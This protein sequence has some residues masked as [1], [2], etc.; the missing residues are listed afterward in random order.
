MPSDS[1]KKASKASARPPLSRERIIA[2]A[3][4]I[5]D[6]RGVG[7]V[8]MREVAS[9]LGVEAMSLYNHV[10]NK[11]D[12]LDGMVDS[13]AAQIDLPH[14]LEDWR[15]V[16]R[17]RAVS[18]HG[19]FTRHPWAPLLIDS[20]GSSGPSALH[21]YD[22]ILGTLLG[23]GFRLEDAARAFSLLDSYIYGFGIE[24][25]NMSAGDDSQEQRAEDMLDKIPAE[26]FPNLRRMASYAME[27][28]YDAGADFDFG[29]QIILDGLERVLSEGMREPA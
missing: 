1:R 27:F 8:T 23:A 7:A 21:Y 19:L 20:R 29:L 2:T 18:A 6:E 24:Q 13:V 26:Q 11:D 17:R 14:D 15:E 9:R 3:V 22:A 4:E 25:F 12:I 5:A 16:M 10:A 28:G